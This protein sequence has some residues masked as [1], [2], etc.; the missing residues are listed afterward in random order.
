MVLITYRK[1]NVLTVAFPSHLQ[2]VQHKYT[3]SQ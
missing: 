3:T 1:S 2:I